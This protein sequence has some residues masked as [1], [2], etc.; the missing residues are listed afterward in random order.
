MAI[1]WETMQHGQGGEPGQ[2]RRDEMRQIADLVA[3]GPVSHALESSF[4]RVHFPVGNFSSG[5][6]GLD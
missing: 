4:A 5:K 2:A 3:S 1:L 6:V